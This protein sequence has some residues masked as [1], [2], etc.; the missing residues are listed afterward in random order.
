MYVGIYAN[1]FP[2]WVHEKICFQELLSETD[3]SNFVFIQ[4][5]GDQFWQLGGH[6]EETGIQ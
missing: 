5:E 1:C 2:E 6:G 4:K 3:E